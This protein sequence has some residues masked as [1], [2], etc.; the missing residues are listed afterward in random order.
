MKKEGNMENEGTITMVIT[1]GLFVIG[2]L[3]GG[4]KLIQPRI[5]TV[6]NEPVK[7]VDGKPIFN[8]KGEQQMEERIRMQS[9]PGTPGFCTIG[10][11]A[12]KYPVV[13]NMQNVL[14]L[15]ERVIT[16]RPAPPAPP[17]GGGIIGRGS[18]P[19]LN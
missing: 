14:F 1:N 11:D 8:D 10:Q 9:F 17:D 7:G 2:K 13:T 4:N 6:Y 3:V 16:P 12:I 19:K 5:F 15:Y 18:D